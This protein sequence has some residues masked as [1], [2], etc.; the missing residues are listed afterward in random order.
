MRVSVR[1]L[2]LSALLTLSAPLLPA[3]FAQQPP[4]ATIQAPNL[5]KKLQDALK[6]KGLEGAIAAVHVVD[7]ESGQELFAHQADEPVNPASNMKLLT[8]A[9]AL[10]VLGPDHTLQTKL[11]AKSVSDGVV[12]NLTLQGHGEP[13][14]QYRHLVAWALTLKRQGITRVQGPIAI[15]DTAHQG[16][17]LPPGFE[18]KREDSS[19]RAPISAMTVNFNGVSLMIS[20]GASQGQPAKIEVFPP[21]TYVQIKNETSTVAGDA[22]RVGVSLKADASHTTFVVKGKVGAAAAKDTWRMRIEDPTQFVGQTFTQALADVG[23]ECS[24]CKIIKAAAPQS[25]VTLVSHQSE[26]LSYALLAMNKWSNNIIAELVLRNLG[27]ADKGPGSSQ[28]GLTK[29]DAVVKSMGV[30][31]KGMKLHNGSG[32]YDG[33]LLTARQLT[34]LLL[35]MHK[36]PYSAEFKASLPIAGMDGTLQNRLNDPATRGNL[37]AKTGTLNEVTSLSGYMHNKKGRAVAFSIIFYKTKVR[38][39]KLRDLQDKLALLIAQSEE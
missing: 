25:G 21:N 1:T 32:L 23:V 33:N 20:P 35:A 38:A 6:D 27:A 10:H 15:D 16:D 30:N 4:A 29:I 9:A 26:P 17:A 13:L 34:S 28:A 24:G 18:Q 22:V 8:A 2:C 31:T 14:L 19:Y 12:H 11:I 5:Q 36:H 7:L 37:R 39:W 3:A